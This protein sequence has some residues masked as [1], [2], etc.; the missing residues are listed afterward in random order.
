LWLEGSAGSVLVD[1]GPD[2]ARQLEREGL[3][4]L[5]GRVVVSHHHL[6]HLLGLDDLCHVIPQGETPLAVHA[7]PH[8][9]ERIRAIFPHLLRPGRERLV[10]CTWH[11]GALLDLG[12]VVLE[13][14][15]THH[16]EEA[17]TT[18]VLLHLRLPRGKARIAYATDMGA[19][20]PSPA[21]RLQGVDVFVG[22]GTYLGPPGHGHPGTD[23]V[24]EIGR[25]LGARRLAVTHVGHWQVDRAEA[26]RRLGADVAICRDGDDL[27]GLLP[28]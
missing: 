1:A 4:R 5:P 17:A 11:A 24:R 9:Q 16:R 14:F 26:R 3:G 6:D 8:A 13:G 12:D 2:V 20:V 27:L 23:R 25:A 21:E 15:E 18:A 28:A 19:A 10:L 22:D 7:G